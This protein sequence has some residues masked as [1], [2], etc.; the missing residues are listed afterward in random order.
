MVRTMKNS[1][2]SESLKLDRKTVERNRRIHMKG[3]CFKLASLIPP[4]HFKPS[5]DMLSQQDQLNVAAC[6]IKQLSEK[7]EKMKLKKEAAIKAKEA[8]N[9]NFNIDAIN[10]IGI[11]LP[12]IEL[13]DLGSSIEVILISGLKKNFM[14][15]EVISVLEEEGAEVVSASFSTVGDKVFHS[16]HAQV[17]ISRVGVETSRVWQRLQDLIY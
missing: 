1:S 11:R 13:K 17:K 9:G 16:V 10:M 15:Y 4:H 8:S 6:Y 7:I 2:S 12:V 3:L 14:L 5:K